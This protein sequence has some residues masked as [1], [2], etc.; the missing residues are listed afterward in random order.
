MDEEEIKV[1][2]DKKIT[3]EL[4]AEGEAR[5]IIRQIQEARK[6]AG[7]RLDEIIQVGLPAW[8]KDYEELIKKEV[9]ASKLVE[10][11]KIEIFRF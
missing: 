2:F 4:K 9:L 8:P 5:E 1:E 3:P 6:Q 11:E 7:C 10:K